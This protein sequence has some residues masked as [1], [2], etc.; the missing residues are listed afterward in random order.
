MLRLQSG[1][2]KEKLFQSCISCRTQYF[3]DFRVVKT[4]SCHGYAHISALL[5]L[6]FDVLYLLDN[7]H[8]LY[9]TCLN[10]L[11][12]LFRANYEQ[13]FHVNVRYLSRQT[14]DLVDWK[15]TLERRMFKASIVWP[16]ESVTFF[17]LHC[18]SILVALYFD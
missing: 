14:T 18:F 13:D 17:F 12:R 7:L 16:L 1:F 6:N 9:K 3:T 2:M 15:Q 10:D 5:F 8:N 4:S 11:T